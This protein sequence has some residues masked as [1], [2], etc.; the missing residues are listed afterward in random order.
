MIKNPKEGKPCQFLYQH[1]T[2]K[3]DFFSYPGLACDL[4]CKTCGFNPEE[5]ER[6]VKTGKFVMREIKHDLHDDFGNV[7]GSVTNNCM[8][9]KFKR[10]KLC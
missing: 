5:Q 9:L 4:S 2:R 10:R 8:V 3:K 6:R 1:E 7:V